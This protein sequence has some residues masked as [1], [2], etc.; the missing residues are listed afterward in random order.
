MVSLLE[1]VLRDAPNDV[2]ALNELAWLRA[3]AADSAYRDTKQ[4]LE[5]TN[6]AIM[7][8]G[9]PDA[10]VFDTQ[11]AAIASDGRYHEAVLA[12]EHALELARN[13][14]DDSLARQ[15]SERVAGYRAGRPY[16]QP[17]PTRG[18]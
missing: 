12:A 6:R 10:G 11:A 3:T 5:L 16:R 15:I 8:G 7:R 17:A 9:A 14:G 1:G 4:A 13:A 2:P 18:R